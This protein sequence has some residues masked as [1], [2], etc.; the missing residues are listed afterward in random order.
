MAKFIL[1]IHDRI[2]FAIK[3]GLT[4]YIPPDKIVTEIHAESM[5]NWRK[6]IKQF[7]ET[8]EISLYLDKLK[9]Q[10]NV[11]LTSGSSPLSA[12]PVDPYI[13]AVAVTA[14]NKQV[15]P[16]DIGRWHERQ[17]HPL[18]AP[19]ADYPVYRLQNNTIFVLPTTIT[20]VTIYHIKKPT[21]PVFAFTLSGDR[22]VYDDDNSVDFEW[23][24]ILFDELMNRVLSNLGINMRDLDLLRHS[25]QEKTMEGR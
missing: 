3:K 15:D 20:Q 7:E 18:A 16:V 25:L 12:L 6:W 5:N 24:E 4:G 19:T 10:N 21:R 9:G 2:N 22:Y 17:N 13:T 14:S 11:T 23:P 8:Q 1:E